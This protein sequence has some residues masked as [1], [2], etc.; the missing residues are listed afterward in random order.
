MLHYFRDAC[1]S[2]AV[3]KRRAEMWIRLPSMRPMRSGIQ[4]RDR[5]AGSNRSGRC[6]GAAPTSGRGKTER[7]TTIHRAQYLF[8]VLIFAE[9]IICSLHSF[10]NVCAKCNKAMT[11]NTGTAAFRCEKWVARTCVSMRARM[12]VCYS[13]IAAPTMRVIALKS[14]GSPLNVQ[15]YRRACD[16]T[17]A[18]NFRSG[19]CLISTLPILATYAYCTQKQVYVPI[20]SCPYRHHTVQNAHVQVHEQWKMIINRTENW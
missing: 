16:R 6:F 1:L 10:D 17:Y 12:S 20:R 11:Q 18:V 15:N 9:F 4:S 14:N 2:I 8:G 5:N 3:S 19:F 13:R 7:T